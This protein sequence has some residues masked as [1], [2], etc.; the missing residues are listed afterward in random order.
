MV[1]MLAGVVFILIILLAAATLVSRNEFVKSEQTEA[2]TARAESA[3]QA[4]EQ[5]RRKAEEEAQQAIAEAKRRIE[6]AQLQAAQAERLA[7]DPR[8]QAELAT[9]ILLAR[10]SEE[11]ARQG[12]SVETSIRDASLKILG[13]E[14]FAAG[15]TS[16]S[17]EGEGLAVALAGLLDRELPC[18]TSRPAGLE[19]C[20][21]YPTAKLETAQIRAAAPASG[22]PEDKAV[23]DARSLV[24]MSRMIAGR[25]D[26]MMLRAPGGT[27]VFTSVGSPAAGA[28]ASPAGT[29]E[30]RF[31]MAVA[32]A[33]KG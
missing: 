29:I 27:S 30:L 14:T 26:L 4:A 7:L 3:L 20:A 18:L 16:L 9:R 12:Y 15:G 24:L 32:A 22:R 5:A 11:L 31:Q 25:P 2:Q 13:T 17:G 10:L 28:G 19:Q 33:P 21:L 6:R 23:A 1:D 8:R